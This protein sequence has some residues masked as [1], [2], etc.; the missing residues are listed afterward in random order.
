MFIKDEE[1]RN[2]YKISSEENLQKLTDGLLHLQQQPIDEATLEK[3][4]RVVHSLKGDS[5]IIGVEDVVTLSDQVEKIL[6]SLKRQ[7]MILTPEVS[8]RL[9]LGL[10]AIGFLVYEAVTGEA[11]GVDTAEILEQLM[12]TV[13][14]SKPLVPEVKLVLVPQT[15]VEQTNKYTTSTNELQD[16]SWHVSTTTASNPPQSRFTFIEDEELRDIYQTT[17]EERLQQLAAG[18]LHLQ[19][20]P[21]DE[22]TLQQLLREAHSLKGDSRSLGVDN[23]VTLTHQLEEILLGI[24]RQEMTLTPELS[25]RLYQGLDAIGFLVYEAVTG[26]PTGVNTAEILNNLVGVVT[27]STTPESL[28]V[29][30]EL[31]PLPTQISVKPV[32]QDLPPASLG[33]SQP[34]HIDTIRVQTLHLDVLITQTEELTLTKNAIAHT[35]TAIEEMTTLWEEWK[36]FYSQAKVTESSSLNAE[37]YT[38]RLEKRIYSLRNSIQEHSTKLDFVA[39]ELREKIRT[40][41]LLPLSTVFELLKR[42]VRDLAKQQS[43]QVELIISGGEITTDKRILEEIKDPLMHMVRNAIDH[44]IETP[45]EREK[46]GKSPVA[47][48]CLRGYQTANNII[49]EVADDGQGLDIEKIK[50]T[51]VKRG[52]YSPKELETM[53]PRQ[54]HALIL[55]PG[56]STQTFITEISGRGI[57][58][59]VVRTSIERLKGNIEIESTPTQGCTFRIQLSTTLAINNVLLFEVQGIV[60][61]LP[62]E[63]VQR[64]LFISPKQILTNEDGKTINLDGQTVLVA[65]L[66]D[67]LQLSNSPAYPHIAKF[68]PQNQT[69]QPC[70]LIKV[71]EEVFGLFVDRLMQTQ[72]VVIKPQSQ[73]LKRVRNVSGATILGSGEVCMILNPSDLLKS[74]QQQTT[75]VVSAKPRKRVKTKPLVLLVEDSIPVRTQ[76]K[77][78]LE[79]AGYEV[80]VAVDGLDGYN[81]LQTR[82]FDAVISDVEMPN[83]DGLSLTKKIRQHPEYETLPI[84]LVTTL[85]SDADKTRG[86]D[87]GA[88][89][90]II[91]SNFNQD[92]LLEILGRLI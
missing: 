13:A 63:F 20:Q 48:I 76:E 58:L 4:V 49:I 24:K 61:A 85:A 3:L 87:V 82:A 86:A 10:D 66:V 44:G 25:D 35:A 80:V 81:K 27:R 33:V 15:S 91:K 8:D 41:R 7:E 36:A 65:N 47:T 52:L 34:Y 9:Y 60:H 79:K 56:F 64:T 17:S 83:L 51:A 12:A 62:V 46:L 71:G 55:A 6:L 21:E 84:I 68:E 29:L 22:A 59:D 32:I 43:K 73:L 72:E 37:S 18:L 78:L 11:T 19:N 89:A 2:L 54:I 75:S 90:Y 50:Q 88:N 26:E 38:E 57:G 69:Q 45:A 74:L 77:R 67:L 28:P 53:T 30:P 42:T 70:I 14:E 5:R 16:V 39:G 40:L 92:V 1:L 23:V 31:S